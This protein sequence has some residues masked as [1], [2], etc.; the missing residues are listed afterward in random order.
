MNYTL[1][2]ESVEIIYKEKSAF[3]EKVHAKIV[4]DGILYSF[5][6]FGKN[7]IIKMKI[8]KLDVRNCDFKTNLICFSLYTDEALGNKK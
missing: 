6:K 5:N 7:R 2:R 8:I 1:L 3:N 4:A